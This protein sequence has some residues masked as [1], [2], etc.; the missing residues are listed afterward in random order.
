M[1]GETSVTEKLQIYVTTLAVPALAGIGLLFVVS[2]ILSYVRLLLSLFVLSG[3]SLREFG[4]KGSW[5]V[6]TGASDGIGKEFAIQLAQKGFNLV[7]VSRTESKLQTLAQ[8]IETKYAGTAV[9]TKIFAMDF[10]KNSEADY[11]RLKGIVDSLEVAVLINNVGQ[12]HDIPVPFI[13][14]PKQEMTDI[15]TVNCIG[16][17]R[18]TQIVAP[19]MAQRGKGLILTMGSIGGL[20]PTPLLAT[21]SGSKAFLQQWSTA[22]GSELKPHGVQVELVISY[23]V[24]SAMSKVRRPSAFIPNPRNF[25]RSVL[26]KIGRSGGAQGVAFTSTPYPTHGLMQWALTTFTGVMGGFVVDR[27][28]GMHEGIR[29]M[30]LRKRERDAKKAS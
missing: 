8:D 23:L 6:V 12:S 28:R 18:V 1:A 10:S 3:R 26:A 11:A 29:K 30:A 14:T 4:R 22:L 7:L 25:V 9:K 16:T 17:L 19:G 24:T 2:K 21:Y 5:A 27:N 13:L 20:L 15:I